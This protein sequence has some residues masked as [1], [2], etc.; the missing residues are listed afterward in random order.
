MEKAELT[1][2]LADGCLYTY[3]REATMTGLQFE[4]L[5]SSILF[6]VTKANEGE[7]LKKENEI[8]KAKVSE[9]EAL[10]ATVKK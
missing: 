9:L 4:N 6:L 5:K 1:I 2:E 3:I 8:L 7:V 10:Q